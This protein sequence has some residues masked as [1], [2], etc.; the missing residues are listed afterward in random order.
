MTL[1]VCT[2]A[3]GSSP[4][5]RDRMSEAWAVPLGPGAVIGNRDQKG[6]Q[7]KSTHS[8][9]AFMQNTQLHFKGWVHI[10]GSTGWNAAP[11]QGDVTC[12]LRDSL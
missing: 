7:E 3:V 5:V 10:P 2:A 4:R 12:V 9:R 6:K 11:P 8:F 1:G